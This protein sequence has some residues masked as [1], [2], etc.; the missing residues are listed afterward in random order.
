M[1]PNRSNA[2]RLTV[3]LSSN[4]MDMKLSQEGMCSG[5]HQA[6]C[7][8]YVPTWKIFVVS[9]KGKERSSLNASSGIC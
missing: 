6:T 2:F 1:T 8:V 9:G 4:M 5:V 7:T 3:V